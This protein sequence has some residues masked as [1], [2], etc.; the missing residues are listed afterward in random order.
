MSAARR[1]SSLPYCPRAN[2]DD[3]A[4]AWLTRLGSIYGLS[5]RLFVD[6]V[7]ASAATSVATPECIELALIDEPFLSN[8]AHAFRIP[9]VQLAAL[10][11]APVDWLLTDPLR[12]NVCIRCIAEDVLHASTPYLRKTWRHAWRIFCP[13]H[14]VQLLPTALKGFTG[15]SSPAKQAEEHQRLYRHSVDLEVQLEESIA[16]SSRTTAI[17]LVVDE[18]E[19]ALD[20]AI[21]GQAPRRDQWG[22]LTAGE[23]LQI[24]QDVTTWALT[25]FEPHPAR[26]AAET[27][28]LHICRSAGAY[29]AKKRRLLP[30]FV[31]FHCV[32]TL[33]DTPEAGL[34]AAALWWTYALLAQNYLYGLAVLHAARDRQFR[35]LKSQCLAGII[36]LHLRTQSWPQRYSKSHWLD[37]GCLL[38]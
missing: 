38:F 23:F 1:W 14:G 24:V 26:P 33:A 18:L 7:L 6:A 8:L 29:F 5:A 27:T 4:I 12:C 19:A 35:L 21:R 11:A 36:W 2:D 25:N 30:S 15:G 16:C 17:V 20:R 22:P 10:Q 28:P 34:R 32:R 31:G 9:K 13:R 3:S 37:L